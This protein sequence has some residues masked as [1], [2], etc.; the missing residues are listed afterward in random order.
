MA[1]AGNNCR[2]VPWWLDRRPGNT[3][4]LQQYT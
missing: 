4:L 2:D 1:G 3:R